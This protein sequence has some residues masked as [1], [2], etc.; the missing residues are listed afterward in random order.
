[1]RQEQ[2]HCLHAEEPSTLHRHRLPQRRTTRGG[3]ATG[4][5]RGRLAR[6]YACRRAEAAVRLQRK[7]RGWALALT[8]RH[9]QCAAVVMLVVGRGALV[10]LARRRELA[11]TVLQTDSAT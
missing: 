8:Y 4:F 9:F 6:A 10:R 11:A 2:P 5:A 7:W 1:M 3:D